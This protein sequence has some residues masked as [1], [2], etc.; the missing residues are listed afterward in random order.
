MEPRIERMK[1]AGGEVHNTVDIRLDMKHRLE[2]LVDTH[3]KQSLLLKLAAGIMK[4]LV[5]YTGQYKPFLNSLADKLGVD[6]LVYLT[7][8]HIITPVGVAY[9]TG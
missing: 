8:E 9:I 4:N 7:R 3:G 6:R 1:L 5:L 2:R